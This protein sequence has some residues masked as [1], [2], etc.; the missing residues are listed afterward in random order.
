[1]AAR[2]RLAKQG[3][4]AALSVDLRLARKHL[5]HLGEVAKKLSEKIVL[6]ARW[7]LNFVNYYHY[8]HDR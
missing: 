4:S 1:M 2:R 8:G 6:K 3:F 5:A 7:E